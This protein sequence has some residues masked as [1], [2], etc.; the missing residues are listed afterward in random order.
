MSSTFQPVEPTLL[1]DANLQRSFTFAW[2]AYG[3][4]FTLVSLN[5]PLFPVHALLPA[6]GLPKL[7]LIVPLYPFCV[8]LASPIS[9]QVVPPFVLISNTA[10]SKVF[11]EFIQ[12]QKLN[13]GGVAPRAKLF[14][15]VKVWSEV[16]DA[17]GVKNELGALWLL[18][19]C[20]IQT[21][22]VVDAVVQKGSIVVVGTVS[23]INTTGGK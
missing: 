23:L 10:P 2:L 16:T 13:T 15:V 18:V 20:A 1:S 3:V 14:V 22:L 9:F 7:E 21:L 19:L 5:A 12:C 17:S 11:S 8:K 6:I 4:K